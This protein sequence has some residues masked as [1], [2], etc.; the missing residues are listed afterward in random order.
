VGEGE[1]GVATSMALKIC[2]IKRDLPL[3]YQQKHNEKDIIN[4]NL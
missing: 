2:L 3:N 1:G 4:E